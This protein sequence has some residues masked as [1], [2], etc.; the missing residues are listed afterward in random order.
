MYK[1]SVNVIAMNTV[2]K[3][4]S[5]FPDFQDMLDRNLRVRMNVGML[6]PE[7]I[8]SEFA[9]AISQ[10]KSVVRKHAN[11]IATIPESLQW[12]GRAGCRPMFQ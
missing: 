7:G 10:V 9:Y 5:F 1:L 11:G 3:K 4:S 8:E 2:P 6:T 12:P